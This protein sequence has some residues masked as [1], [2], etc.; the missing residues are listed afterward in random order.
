MSLPDLPMALAVPPPV[1][2]CR[3]CGRCASGCPRARPPE[4][5]PRRVVRLLQ[6]GRLQEA[7]R[8]PFLHSCRYCGKCLVKCPQGLEV[9]RIIKSL[10]FQRFLCW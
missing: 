8:H 5:S 10:V 9:A 2:A 3:Q 6:L 7:A 1:Q 4:L